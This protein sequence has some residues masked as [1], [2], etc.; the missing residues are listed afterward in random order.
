[1]NLPFCIRVLNMADDVGYSKTSAVFLCVNALVAAGILSL[2]FA[3]Y[4]GGI[5]ES[6]ITFFILAIPSLACTEWILETM[7]RAE[8][9][10]RWK[11]EI[12]NGKTLDW[13]AN[14]Y[15]ATDRKFE[16]GDLCRL[17]LIEGSVFCTTS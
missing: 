5:I 17:F 14:C 15:V 8:A 12:A 6:T 10:H 4:H 16:V 7:A 1:M 2:P 13:P 11:D 3:F 9:L